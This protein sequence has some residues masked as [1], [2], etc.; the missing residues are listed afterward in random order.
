MDLLKNISELTNLVNNTLTQ[1]IQSSNINITSATQPIQPQLKQET[2]QAD[3][4][5]RLM[6]QIGLAIQRQGGL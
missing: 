3:Q 1:Q 2:S 6:N 5:D 4:E